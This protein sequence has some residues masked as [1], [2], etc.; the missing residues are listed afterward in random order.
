MTAPTAS[1]PNTAGFGGTP[2][3]RRCNSTLTSGWTV[4]DYRRGAE[5]GARSR[6]E[7]LEGADMTTVSINALSSGNRVHARR[8]AGF[9]LVEL[10]VVIGIIALLIGI[11]LPAL[12]RAR[13][14]A[15]RVKCMSN[16][17]QVMLAIFMYEQANKSLPGPCLPCVLDPQVIYPDFPTD[18]C[19]VN[20]GGDI[21]DTTSDTFVGKNFMGM[22]NLSQ[23]ELLGQYFQDTNVWRCPSND[24][25]RLTAHPLQ[26][27]FAGKILG[28]TY[29]INNRYENYP[30]FNFG[31]WYNPVNLSDTT[32]TTATADRNNA[33]RP[34][35]LSQVQGFVTNNTLA[36]TVN[37]LTPL[38]PGD[39]WMMA[40]LDGPMF[41]TDVSSGFGICVANSNW[42]LVPFQPGHLSGFQRGR[43]WVFFD[44]HGEFR[45]SSM[46]PADP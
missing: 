12:S 17:H 28:Y 26:D 22:R 9:T 11:L 15:N 36:T 44:G 31:Y 16:M 29:M 41:P 4:A 42:N 13:E 7:A 21:L 1:C 20:N 45:L 34:L 38:L 5:A 27:A 23:H 14:G 35:R 2:A 25:V 8:R 30:R 40:D 6:R 10:L 24:Q 18:L 3:D 32:L 37:N 43:N 33:V 19:G 46:S 39:N